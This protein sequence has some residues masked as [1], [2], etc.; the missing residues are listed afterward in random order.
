MKNAAKLIT[1]VAIVA[2]ATTAAFAVE[3]GNPRKGKYLYKKNCKVCHVDGAEG[4]KL[5]PMD[6]T[7]SQWERFFERDKHKDHPDAWANFSEGDLKDIHQY[8]YDHAADSD[9]PET[10]G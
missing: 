7:Q 5:T 1:I 2:T 6:K 3:G 8:L 4:G 10:C 9:Q